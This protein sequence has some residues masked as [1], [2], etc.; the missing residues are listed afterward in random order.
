MPAVEVIEVFPRER[1]VI[2]APSVRGKVEQ[3]LG[4]IRGVRVDAVAP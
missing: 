2:F 1:L 3:G 4:A